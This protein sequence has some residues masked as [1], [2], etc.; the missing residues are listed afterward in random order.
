MAVN[1]CESVKPPFSLT[2]SP[3]PSPFCLFFY[4]LLYSS[5][6]SRE[7]LLPVP[8][9]SQGPGTSDDT[10]LYRG[11][12]AV[13]V[14][15]PV[16]FFCVPGLPGGRSGKGMRVVIWDRRESMSSGVGGRIPFIRR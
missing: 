8:A 1:L 5:D 6:D 11:C 12:C 15:I 2:R 4:P 3:R 14:A 10:V 13:M 7:G 9:A 16:P